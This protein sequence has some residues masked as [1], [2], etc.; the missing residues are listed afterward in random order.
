MMQT[1]KIGDFVDFIDHPI[2]PPA[3]T[4]QHHYMLRVAPNREIA[5][6]AKL[7]ERGVVAYLPKET[8]TRKTGWNRYKAR[9]VAIFPGAIFIPDF[10]ADLRRLKTI[11]DA[12]IGYVRCESVPV[13]ISPKAMTEI[14]K[15]EKLLDVPPGQR[16]RAFFVDQQVRIE[17]GQFEGWMARVARLDRNHRLTVL[18]NMFGRMVHVELNEDQVEAV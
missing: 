10:E 8:E 7:S 11:A 5:T 17:Q 6:E 13:V 3:R 16:K 18:V 15:F 14:R 4:A 1:L 12:I 9:A 2:A